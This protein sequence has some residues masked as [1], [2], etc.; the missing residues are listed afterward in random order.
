MSIVAER[1]SRFAEIEAAG[2]SAVYKRL[3]LA[4]AE[5]ERATALIAALP[6]LKQ[7]PNL[8]LAAA[9][10]VGIPLDAD[11]FAAELVAR[12]PEVR[13]VVLERSTQTNEAGRCAVL[14][15]LLAALDGPLALI[16]VGASAG[17]CLVPDRYSYRYRSSDGAFALDPVDG[18]SPVVLD[19][20]ARGPVPERIPEVGWRAG[21]DLNPLDVRDA[22][23]VAWLETLV[24]PGQ[25]DRAARLRDAAVLVAA[26][27]PVL[28][29]GDAQ[30]GL[31]ALVDAAPAGMTVVVF[32]SAVLAYFAAE[33]RQSFATLVRSL[34]VSWVSYE[35]ALVL[36]EIAGRL[37]QPARDDEFIVAVDGE[38]VLLADPHARYYRGIP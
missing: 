17:L 24:W 30:E 32:H 27:P 37:Q 22:G 13:S 20:E 12:W 34:P 18:V 33:A 28:V 35:G 36:P 15:P 7:Q 23:E 26:D 19:C 16:E 10:F 11:R 9:R 6:V 3:A 25:E 1:Y 14:L 5:D 21:I 4:I 2:R 8:V 38:P 31:A 29:R